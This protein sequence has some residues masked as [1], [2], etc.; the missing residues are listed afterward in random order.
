MDIFQDALKTVSFLQEKVGKMSLH[1]TKMALHMIL[2]YPP[3]AVILLPYSEE[4]AALQGTW[5][6][7]PTIIS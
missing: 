6:L 5:A 4:K 1:C 3:Y 2:S 7:I